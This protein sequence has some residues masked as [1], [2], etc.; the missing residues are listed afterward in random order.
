[1]VSCGGNPGQQLMLSRQGMAYLYVSCMG[2]GKGVWG[3]T[4]TEPRLLAGRL[5]SLLTAQVQT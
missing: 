5:Q 2:G 1:M 4:K 3:A